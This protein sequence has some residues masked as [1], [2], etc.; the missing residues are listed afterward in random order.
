MGLPKSKISLLDD[1]ALFNRYFV[2]GGP[3]Y[4]YNKLQRWTTSEI[5]LNPITRKPFS[6][7]AMQQSANRHLVRNYQVPE[8][9]NAFFK[10]WIDCGLDPLTED[11]YLHQISSKARWIFKPTQYKNFCKKHPELPYLND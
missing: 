1:E 10:F 5:G 8:V 7:S 4:S 9:K 11:E 2:E 6:V 3:G